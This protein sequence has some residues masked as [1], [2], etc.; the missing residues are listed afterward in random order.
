MR[1]IVRIALCPLRSNPG[2]QI[3][4]SDSCLTPSRDAHF[5]AHITPG[6]ANPTKPDCKTLGHA[7]PSPRTEKIIIAPCRG[8]PRPQIR[9]AGMAPAP[10]APS[11]KTLHSI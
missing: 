4:R 3:A 11:R 1:D 10:Y 7:A 8:S 2:L 5:Y 6:H 9:M